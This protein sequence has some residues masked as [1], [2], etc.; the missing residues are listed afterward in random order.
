MKTLTGTV[1]TEHKLYV[2]NFTLNVFE[3]FWQRLHAA[4]FLQLYIMLN[5]PDYYATQATPLQS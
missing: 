5:V 4:F 2:Q 1:F 3:I